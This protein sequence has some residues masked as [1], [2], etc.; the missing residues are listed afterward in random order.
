MWVSA[1]R[2]LCSVLWLLV[3]DGL[4][5][6]RAVYSPFLS[7][8]F[9][10]FPFSSWSGLLALPD[11]ILHPRRFISY[12][13]FCWLVLPAF[14]CG[15]SAW[16]TLANN[17]MPLCSRSVLFDGGHWILSNRIIAEA[18]NLWGVDLISIYLDVLFHYFYQQL[19]TFY[20]A[21]VANLFIYDLKRW[22]SRKNLLLFAF[23]D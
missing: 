22:W 16:T 1:W 11:N 4:W 19:L 21:D 3:L 17:I 2:V 18:I 8:V 10:P 23:Y 20:Q 12:I 15:A 6:F 7:P 13:C 14:W 5:M 9:L